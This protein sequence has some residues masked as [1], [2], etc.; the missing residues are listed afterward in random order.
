MGGA[1]PWVYLLFEELSLPPNLLISPNYRRFSSGE[2]VSA[3]PRCRFI[4]MFSG[5]E[6]PYSA[7]AP[8]DVIV[9][10]NGC[11]TVKDGKVDYKIQKQNS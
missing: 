3:G 9:P 8:S 2:N 5:W 4:R 1:T 6:L 11:H 10:F 7:N